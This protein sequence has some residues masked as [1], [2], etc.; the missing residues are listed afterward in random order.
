MFE[1]CAAHEHRETWHR[2]CDDTVV[3]SR[4]DHDGLQAERTTVLQPYFLLTREEDSIEQ[5]RAPDP[6]TEQTTREP[7]WGNL[8]R[9]D[10]RK[11]DLDEIVRGA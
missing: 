10:E 3:S 1:P 11:V 2:L 4:C 6:R 8:A 7:D 5:F 9:Y